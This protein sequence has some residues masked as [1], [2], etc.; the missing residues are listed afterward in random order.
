MVVTFEKYQALEN[1]FLVLERKLLRLNARQLSAFSKNM[2]DRRTGV[3]A[4][5][6]VL[7]SS[8]RKGERKVDIYNAD[9]SWAE[10]SGNGLRIAAAFLARKST[11]KRSFSFE[12]G[13]SVDSVALVK[14]TKSGWTFRADM[15]G[16]HFEA[17]RV[18]V[19]TRHRYIINSPL[20]IA[21]TKLPVTCLSIGNPHTVIVVRDFEFDWMA[22]G[23][24]LERSRLF[25]NGTNVEFV[26]ILTRKH[27]LVAEW[28]RG[29]GATGSSGT[30]AA[31][32]VCGLAIQGLVD[33]RC[34]VEFPAGSL[35]VHWNPQTER[36]EL[37]GPVTYV[38]KGQYSYP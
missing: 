8:S 4:D 17:A 31:A 16:P 29:A 3:G 6:I 35:G 18:P 7:L 32:V 5:G 1:D 38:M 2:C 19:K 30:G 36:V 13:T 15:A 33:R 21:G 11:R 25:P 37:T 34:K 12:T 10:K 26:Q 24:D 28:E 23:A 27:V 9:G 22:L 14:K 20:K